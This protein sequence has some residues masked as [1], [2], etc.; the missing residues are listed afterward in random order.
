MRELD[1]EGRE[2]ARSRF[3]FIPFYGLAGGVL[4]STATYFALRTNPSIG[5]K[6]LRRMSLFGGSLGALIALQLE[7]Y[8]FKRSLQARQ[9]LQ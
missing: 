3:I 5:Q 6:G 1:P 7:L 9:T 4:G 8:L 2:E